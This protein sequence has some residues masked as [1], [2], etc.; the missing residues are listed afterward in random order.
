MAFSN[1][2]YAVAGLLPTYLTDGAYGD[3]CVVTR[4]TTSMNIDY[5]NAYAQCYTNWITIGY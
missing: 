3:Y 1:V 4:T 2:L 5:T